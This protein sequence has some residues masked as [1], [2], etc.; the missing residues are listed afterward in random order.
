[1]P[2]D[3]S[4]LAVVAQPD[5]TPPILGVEAE[6]ADDND[7]LLVVTATEERAE[8]VVSARSASQDITVTVTNVEEPGTVT[9]NRLQTRVEATGLTATLEDPDGPAGDD[10]AISVTWL[11]SVPKVSRPDLDNDDHW[12]DAAGTQPSGNTQ[13]EGYE[14]DDTDATAFLRVKASYTDGEGADKEAYAKIA[15]PVEPARADAD[16]EEPAFGDQVTTTFEVA[17]S[18]MVG[19]VVGTVRASDDDSADILSHELAATGDS[20]GK[21]EIDIETGVIKIA[22]ALNHEDATLT[23]GAYTVTVTAYDAN[24]ESGTTTV[25]ITATDV[26]EAPEE[27][28]RHR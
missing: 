16:N 12:T 19:T 14:T 28:D 25:T 11:W 5:A 4:R 15:N 26:N 2:S 21:F 1:M 7:Y 27:A 24:N 3:E 23:D 18:T 9:L 8:G 10:T 20:D 17:E 22:S 6:D 13:T